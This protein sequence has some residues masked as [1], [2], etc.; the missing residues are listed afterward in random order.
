[1]SIVLEIITSLAKSVTTLDFRREHLAFTISAMKRLGCQSSAK[2][3]A[4]VTLGSDFEEQWH[5]EQWH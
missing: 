1:M 3:L 4:G 5:E 2:L